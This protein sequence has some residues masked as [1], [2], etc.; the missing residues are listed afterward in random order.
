MRIEY[1]G[2]RLTHYVERLTTLGGYY[3]SN[4]HKAFWLNNEFLASY[5]EEFGREILTVGDLRE[6]FLRYDRNIEGSQYSS[7]IRES[8]PALYESDDGPLVT[9]LPNRR[10]RENT[11][12]VYRDFLLAPCP[13][14]SETPEPALP[15]YPEEWEEIYD[16][17]QPSEVRDSRCRVRL[18]FYAPPPPFG[19]V[20]FG[21]LLSNTVAVDSGWWEPGHFFAKV[22]NYTFRPTFTP[23]RTPKDSENETFGMEIEIS[24]ILSFTELQWIVT[25][26]EPKQQPFFYG[27]SDSS[28]NGKYANKFELVT[29]PSSP[30]YLK[31]NFRLL[32]KKIDMLCLGR[33][34][35]VRDVIDIGDTDVLNNG[36]H[37]HIGKTAFDTGPEGH[38]RFHQ[39]RFLTFLNRPDKDMHNWLTMISKR[40][41]NLKDSQYCHPHPH[42]SGSLVSCYKNGPLGSHR[43]SIAHDA[44]ATIEVRMFYGKWDL[45]HLF[46]CIE[47]CQAMIAF[48]EFSR[49]K[50]KSSEDIIK[51]FTEWLHTQPGYRLLKKEVL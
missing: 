40:P 21:T 24:T 34:L 2:A 51:S 3:I 4:C 47:F 31:Q 23:L 11:G 16:I 15:E 30:R 42:L 26:V 38:L 7:R 20:P 43:Y 8:C 10:S 41:K 46:R 12:R 39:N 9:W 17:D 18:A 1:N 22:N 50:N 33:G 27:K 44:G 5:R 36:I 32:F 49:F 25:Q 19:T 13:V 28:I 48:S 6:W 45:E 35:Q 37:I 29:M 14:P